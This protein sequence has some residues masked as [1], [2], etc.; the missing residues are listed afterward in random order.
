MD[1]KK[2]AVA[3][4]LIVLV[5]LFAVWVS[6][7]GIQTDKERLE[8]VAMQD[9]G[10]EG[11]PSTVIEHEPAKQIPEET[12]GPVEERVTPQK[13]VETAQAEAPAPTPP[14][15][16]GGPCAADSPA[17][18]KKRAA[19][20]PEGMVY[21]PGGAFTMGASG[22]RQNADDG[23]AHKVCVNGFYMDKLEVTNAQFQKF[24][25]A[26]GYVT[27]AEK[28]ADAADSR[29]WRHPNGADSDADDMLNYPVVCVSW[30][31]ANAYAL[32]ADK[33]LPT[34]AE[35]EKAARGTDGRIF[36]WGNKSP[37]DSTLNTADK[38]A[39]FKWSSSSLDDKY[40]G[41]APVGSFPAGKSVYGAEDMSGNVWEWCWDWWDPGYYK[42]S[43]ASNPVGPASGEYRVIRGGS[44]YYHLDGARTTQ[45]MYFRPEGFSAA[46]G[47]RCVADVK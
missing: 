8:R 3:I 34:E 13:V 46:I 17:V 37:A 26:T 41:V 1:P 24:V 35:W 12:P 16:S 44:W 2:R 15:S 4:S 9:S 21:I 38:S 22:D 14:V 33:R 5:I 25:E 23:P 40:K 6:R 31:D 28:H 19:A 10:E 29:T 39:S 30:N 43:S 11:K 27:D 36:P 20:A 32:W 7:S 47:F 45:R 42:V 18:A